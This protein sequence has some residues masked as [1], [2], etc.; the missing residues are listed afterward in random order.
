MVNPFNRVPYASGCG[1]NIHTA[2]GLKVN[3][4]F[5]RECGKQEA[6]P[7]YGDGKYN[8]SESEERG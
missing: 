7:V 3:Q 5:Q 4:V 8:P 2:E 6:G 1:L